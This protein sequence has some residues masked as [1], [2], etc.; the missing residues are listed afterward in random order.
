[1]A[2]H[3]WGPARCSK[4]ILACRCLRRCHGI[5]WIT[6]PKGQGPSQTNSFS[7]HLVNGLESHAHMR[8]GF[9][10]KS[11]SRQEGWSSSYSSFSGT[12]SAQCHQCMDPWKVREGKP[13]RVSRKSAML[14]AEEVMYSR[15]RT[16]RVP[17]SG[18]ACG[19]GGGRYLLDGSLP[20]RPQRDA[21]APAVEPLQHSSDDQ[22]P[23]GR[24]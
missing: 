8:S 7:G 24:A 21:L 1:M 16:V 4:H 15:G 3:R 5:L 18:G 6:G 20:P 9:P 11:K 2:T 17:G 22:F 10:P 14:T 13:I 19:P 23:P 12:R